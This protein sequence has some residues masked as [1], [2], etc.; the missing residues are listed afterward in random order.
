MSHVTAYAQPDLVWP[1]SLEACVYLHGDV[2]CSGLS[3]T[4][5]EKTASVFHM[6]HQLV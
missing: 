6:Q 4:A 1:K 5:C 2:H 3:A